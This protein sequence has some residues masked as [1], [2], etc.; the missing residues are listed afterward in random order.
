MGNPAP[1][2]D[3][4][5]QQQPPAGDAPKTVEERLDA[6]DQKIDGLAGKIDQVLGRLTGQDS[7]AAGGHG[8]AAADATPAPD[9]PALVQQGVQKIMDKQKRDTDAATAKKADEDWRKSV[10]DRLAERKPAEPATGRR[11]GLQKFLF[12][13][14]D[15]R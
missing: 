14:P 15:Q 13:A 9:I 7:A 5:G 8:P 12:G 2:A 10:D 3:G 1:P 4:A 6:Q 11:T